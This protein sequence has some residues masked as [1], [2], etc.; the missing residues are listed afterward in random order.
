MGYRRDLAT[1]ATAV[2]LSL[3]VHVALFSLGPKGWLG[4]REPR[5]GTL[6]VQYVPALLPQEVDGK[7]AGVKG[8][9]HEPAVG[10]QP[11]A[12]RGD[13][14]G[15]RARAKKTSPVPKPAGQPPP[16]PQAP[17][18]DSV[19]PSDPSPVP[20]SAG[21]AEEATA[22]LSVS[23]MAS[24]T[25][26]ANGKEEGPSS[27]RPGGHGVLDLAPTPRELAVY[28][29]RVEPPDP[30][31]ENAREASVALG[32]RDVRYRSYLDR[33]Q[34]SIDGSWR[35][36]EAL[37]AAGRSGSVVLRF[38]LTSRGA[39]EDVEVDRTSG[40]PILDAEAMKAVRRSPLPAFPVHWTIIRLHL[41]AQFDYR[42]E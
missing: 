38:T 17:S 20:P 39:T 41:L 5:P 42:L 28:G 24:Q 31:G 18:V 29:N 2:G 22:E 35:W 19:R 8:A 12:P 3:L 27:G 15:S 13:R 1:Q 25:P 6:A 21:Q 40:N 10:P 23:P 33:V 36:R 34:E 32:E 7:P 11:K 14:I 26:G 16:Q 30:A 9:G 4:P 37:L